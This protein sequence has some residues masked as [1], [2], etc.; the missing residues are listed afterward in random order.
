MN[1]GTN[2]ACRESYCG[3]YTTIN[4]IATGSHPQQKIPCYGL[5][6]S[7]AVAYALL[8]EVIRTINQKFCC[9][10]ADERCELLYLSHAD[11][12]S[13]GMVDRAGRKPHSAL[14]GGLIFRYLT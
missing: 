1:S 13:L 7:N 10:A 12:S 11:F 5:C 3:L 2:R 9:A 8:M 14:P 6:G 4:A